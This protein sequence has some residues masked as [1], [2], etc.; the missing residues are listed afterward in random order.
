MAVSLHKKPYVRFQDLTGLPFERLHVLGFADNDGPKDA[1]RRWRCEC[2]CGGYVIAQGKLLLN[3]QRRSCGCIRA[4]H[5]RAANIKRRHGGVDSPEYE[6]WKSMLTR[7]TNPNSDAWENYGGRGIKVCNRWLNSFPD[8]LTD[9]GPRPSL[10]YS[11]DRFPDNDG[12]YEPGNCRWAT[13][14]EQGRN[15]RT[16]LNLTVEGETRCLKEWAE[17]SG[18]NRTTISAR[19]RR[20]W[21]VAEAIFA[22]A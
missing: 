18:V 21:S 9:M 15:R 19:L 2:A 8:F 10:D 7:C 3:G 17:I 12:N 16:N 13:V 14:K 20:G 6:T 5:A 11:I 1:R 22:P 4:E